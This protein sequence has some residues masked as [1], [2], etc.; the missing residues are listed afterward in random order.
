M[1]FANWQKSCVLFHQVGNY[2][3]PYLTKKSRKRLH[4][5]DFPD[6]KKSLVDDFQ[7]LVAHFKFM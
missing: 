4:R 5:S 1:T 3:A 6:M 2:Q 7:M